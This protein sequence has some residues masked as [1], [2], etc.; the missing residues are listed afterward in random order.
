MEPVDLSTVQI[1][2]AEQIGETAKAAILPALTTVL[3]SGEIAAGIGTAL[4]TAASAAQ[5]SIADVNVIGEEG[6]QSTARSKGESA[7]HSAFASPFSADATINATAHVNWTIAN[8]R[9]NLNT[10]IGGGG[11]SARGGIIYPF[12]KNVAGY[13]N[14]GYVSG[15]ARLIKVAE[16]GTPEA[17]I[18]L[19]SQRR[20]RGL[21]LWEQTGHM[22]GVP[23]FARGGIIGGHE[24]EGLRFQGSGSGEAA[25]GGGIT[26]N[27]GGVTVEVNVEGGDNP[28]IAAAIAE[29]SGEIAEQVAGILA[30][31]F[32][33]QFENTPTKGVA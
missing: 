1:T 19:G 18:P 15:G 17:I 9:P 29:Q 28:D 3:G 24:D 32:N 27:V 6:L 21:E 11:G 31:A 10:S 2:G 23:G 22:L 12:G 33:G 14:G 4:D 30:D 20:K 26:V 25:G 16:E 8:P 7:I 13:S 5:T